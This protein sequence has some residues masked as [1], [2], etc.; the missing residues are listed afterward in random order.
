MTRL[1][2]DLG[3]FDFEVEGEWLRASV[4]SKIKLGVLKGLMNSPYA[5]SDLLVERS[6]IESEYVKLIQPAGGVK[7]SNR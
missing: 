2:T 7:V 1:A 6:E 4:P 5:I 3:A